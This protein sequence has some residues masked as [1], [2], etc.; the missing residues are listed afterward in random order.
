MPRKSLIRPVFVLL[1]V[2]LLALPSV[3]SAVPLRAES[4]V[5]DLLDAVW[6]WASMQWSRWMPATKAGC[7]ID[8]IGRPILCS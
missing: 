4:S 7:G 5:T 1:A 2:I 3:V 6:Q 8:P